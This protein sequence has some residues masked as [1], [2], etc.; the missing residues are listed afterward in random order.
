MVWVWALLTLLTLDCSLIQNRLPE[1]IWGI[2]LNYVELKDLRKV[3]RVNTMFG[4]H[5]R[6]GH[7][8]THPF[9]DIHPDSDSDSDFLIEAYD[10]EDY[11]DEVM[12]LFGG[13]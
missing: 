1:E 13:A 9:N 8:D 6:S 7:P 11:W 12:D 2:I 10:T 5:A 4:K 3:A